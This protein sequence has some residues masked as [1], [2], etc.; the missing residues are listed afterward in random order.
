MNEE[1][2]REP[3]VAGKSGTPQKRFR[4]AAT[5]IVGTFAALLVG[6]ILFYTITY[7]YYIPRDTPA[8]KVA[9]AF[10]EANK[11]LDERNPE[12]AVKR[13]TELLGRI[14]PQENP[15]LYENAKRLRGRCY[16]WLAR[17][18]DNKAYLRDAIADFEDALQVSPPDRSPT[19][20]ATLQVLLGTTCRDLGAVS[21]PEEYLPKA[22]RALESALTIYTREDFPFDYASTQNALGIAYAS[23]ARVSDKEENL[24]KAIHAYEAA[25]E[26]LAGDPNSAAVN[27]KVRANLEAA[28]QAQR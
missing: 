17:R 20:Y 5:F 12:D 21:Q 24:T 23:L 8:Q 13:L 7:F 15:Q 25:L 4:R 27:E 14:S 10:R 11:L 16:L 26:V 9:A 1:A 19:T 6:A 3:D 28:K 22:V 18:A 2:S